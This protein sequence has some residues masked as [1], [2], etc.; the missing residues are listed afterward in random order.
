MALRIRPTTA[1]RAAKT[2]MQGINARGRE[3]IPSTRPAIPRPC[4]ALV[5]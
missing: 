3:I 4:P 5:F 2:L 1:T